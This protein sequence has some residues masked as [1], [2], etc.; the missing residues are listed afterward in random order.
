M[1]SI[2]ALF[3]SISHILEDDLQQFS[4]MVSEKYIK[5]SDFYLCAGET[6]KTMG[7]VK[8]GLFRYYYSNEEGEEYTKGF[9]SDTSLLLS[10]SA[11]IEK[12]ASH[13][14][15]QALQD[16]HI[17][18]V[19][20]S[21]MLKQFGHTHWFKDVSVALVQKAYCIKEERERQLLL[22]SAEDRYKQFFIRFPGLDKHVKQ[23]YIA[24]FLGIKPETLSRIRKKMG[25]LT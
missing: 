24:S 22:L 13:F 18:E 11:L 5:C 9:F 2:I 15:I 20:Y 3:N 25:L 12:R 7:F 21:K 19:N 1:S 23:H 10:Y 8:S 16:S 14:T 17:E 6:P 4:S